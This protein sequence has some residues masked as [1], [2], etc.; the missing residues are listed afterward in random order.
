M[1][2]PARGSAHGVITVGRRETAA[3][4][5]PCA[6]CSGCHPT[7][8]R[9]PGGCNATPG[10]TPWRHPTHGNATG[11][12]CSE[13]G[14]AIPATDAG[15]RR[16]PRIPAADVTA[17]PLLRLRGRGR[18]QFVSRKSIGHDTRKHHI[19]RRHQRVRMIRMVSSLTWYGCGLASAGHPPLWAQNAPVRSNPAIGPPMRQSVAW[20]RCRSCS[21]SMVLNQIRR[22]NFRAMV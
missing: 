14:A 6:R 19:A 17:S 22:A 9:R 12:L 7:A 4:A 21:D 13:T 11:R 3:P 15:Q 16:L 18:G 10:R 1:T 2:A 5:T 8:T 20:W